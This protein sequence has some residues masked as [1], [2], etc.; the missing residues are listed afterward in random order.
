MKSPSRTTVGVRSIVASNR[1]LSSHRVRRAGW[2]VRGC[3]RATSSR[4][5][6]PLPPAI[7]F[8]TP[9]LALVDLLQL[10]L[11]PL[12]RVLGLGALD[13]LGEHV[14]DDVLRIRLRGLA[15]RRARVAEHARL[16]SSLPEDLQRLV[17]LLPHRVLLPLLGG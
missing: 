15:G 2:L 14:H 5:A 1:S 8:F 13:G 12:G 9:A 11:R 4:A 3:G 10:A 6:L 7:G 16:P 17:D